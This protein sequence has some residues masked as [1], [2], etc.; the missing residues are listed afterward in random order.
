MT[1]VIYMKHDFLVLNIDK[2]IFDVAAPVQKAY[3]FLA[4]R[5]GIDIHP[6]F[7]ERVLDTRGS[8]R[9]RLDRE[10]HSLSKLHEQAAELSARYIEESVADNQIFVNQSENFLRY[11]DE[12]SIPYGVVSSMPRSFVTQMTE[13]YPLFHP[14]FSI[15]Q[16]QILE[17]KPEPDLYLMAARKAGV[18]PNR[19]LA[20]ENTHLGAEAA[21]LANV[22]VIYISD[23]TKSDEP[24]T[25]YSQQSLSDLNELIKY[26]DKAVK[27][28]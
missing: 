28:N 27:N 10:F 15:V 11:L 12:R 2:T 24:E 8:S 4:K 25:A 22:K 16:A 6:A 5:N 19:L 9:D 1:W 21:F 3:K 26:L 20:I 17:G 13:M 14:A 23:E 18:H 7:L